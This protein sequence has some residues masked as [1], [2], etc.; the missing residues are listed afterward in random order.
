MALKL[1]WRQLITFK[2]K[3]HHEASG[4]S[5]DARY[6][7]YQEHLEE[8]LSACIG[9]IRQNHPDATLNY[10]GSD[11]GGPIYRVEEEER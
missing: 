8:A 9:F 3:Q 11:L 7:F 10:K 1:D 6:A 4:T 2:A 5:P